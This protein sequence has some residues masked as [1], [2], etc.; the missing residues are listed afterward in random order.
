M[1]IFLTI[2]IKD[3]GFY[4]IK[5]RVAKR[6]KSP[7]LARHEPPLASRTESLQPELEVPSYFHQLKTL[8]KLVTLTVTVILMISTIL[9]TFGLELESVLFNFLYQPMMSGTILSASR[10]LSPFGH[11][12]ILYLQPFDGLLKTF[13]KFHWCYSSAL[14]KKC[15]SNWKKSIWFKYTLVWCKKG[16]REKAA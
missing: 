7:L 1:G 15:V 9:Y 12:T 2:V 8:L 4:P 6:G 13:D 3:L 10:S 14:K 16:N 5:K 11:H